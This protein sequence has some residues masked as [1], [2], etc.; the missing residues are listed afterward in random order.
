MIKFKKNWLHER[1][2]KN[3]KLIKRKKEKKNWLN[4]KK[5]KKCLIRIVLMRCWLLGAFGLV[6]ASKIKNQNKL[7]FK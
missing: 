2:E 3:K 6:A 5:R 4:E 1:I 7:I